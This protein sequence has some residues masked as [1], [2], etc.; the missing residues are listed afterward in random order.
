MTSVTIPNSVTSIEDEAF[1]D[2][3]NL[4]E[5]HITDIAAWCKIVFEVYPSNPLYYAHNLYVNG[6]LVTDLVIPDGVASIGNGAFIHCSN[7]TSV[8]IPNSVTSIGNSA[9]EDCNNLKEVHITDIATWCKINFGLFNSSN[10]LYYAHNL[11]V[12]GTLLTDLVIPDGVTSIGTNAFCGCSSLTSV[13][14]PN[15]VTSIESYAF[16][17]C[18]NRDEQNKS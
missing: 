12:N 1:G 11:Y 2:C 18:N 16:E 17:D 3:N 13:T 10:P 5:V 6:T 8:T 14:V 9:F 4:R 7:L 15:S